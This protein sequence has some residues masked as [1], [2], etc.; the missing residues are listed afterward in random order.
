M[1]GL[2][3]ESWR[4]EL[5][6]PRFSLV[7]FDKGGTLIDFRAMWCAWAIEMARRL[8]SRLGFSFAARFFDALGF[9]PASGWIDPLGPLAVLPVENLR[10]FT[11]DVLIQAGLSPQDA[12]ATVAATWFVPDPVA[13]VHPLA[14]LAALFHALR[15]RGLKIAIAT[16]DQRASTEAGLT[17]LGISAWADALVCADDGLPLKPSPDMV[18]AACGKVGVSPQRTV[19]VGDSITD[20][21]M[22]RSAGAGLNIGV[23]SGVTPAELLA[24]H[25]DVLIAHVGELI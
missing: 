12:V 22:G 6:Q 13:S 2:A 3:P 1:P 11:V 21:Q 7:V 14:D 19:V 4:V 18:W 25:A 10:G 5:G 24:P 23:L 15:E 17:T 20:M 9:D 16:M 8:E